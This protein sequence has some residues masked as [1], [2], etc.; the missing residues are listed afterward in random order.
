[1]EK[2][3]AAVCCVAIG[4]AAI[5]QLTLHLLDQATADQCKHR[6][7]PAHSDQLHRD[8]CIANNYEL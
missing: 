6:K 3:G 8:W 2:L 7:W 4:M 1:M 5:T